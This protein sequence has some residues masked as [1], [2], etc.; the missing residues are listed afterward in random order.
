MKKILL[1]FI[2]ILGLSVSSFSQDQVISGKYKT[3]SLTVDWSTVTGTDT[4]IVIKATWSGHVYI[5]IDSTTYTGGQPIFNLQTGVNSAHPYVDYT[6][7]KLPYT[8]I[9]STSAAFYAD[10]WAA[11]RIKVILTKNSATAGSTVI[12]LT[13]KYD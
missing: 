10:F 8:T 9:N 4:S 7:N 3:D 2:L 6:H 13:Y 12:T 5:Q 1:L 11:K